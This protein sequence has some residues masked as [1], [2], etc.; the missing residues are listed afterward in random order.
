MIRTFRLGQVSSCLITCVYLLTGCLSPH[1][2]E[3]PAVPR[4]LI[5]EFNKNWLDSGQNRLLFHDSITKKQYLQDGWVFD[6]HPSETRFPWPRFTPEGGA[7]NL[8]WNQ[9][10]ERRVRIKLLNIHV[11]MIDD[12]VFMSIN[13]HP[14][15]R[16]EDP[17]PIGEYEFYLPSAYQNEGQNLLRI[18]LNPE[19]FPSPEDY[20]SIG[21]HSLH[22]TLGAVVK[23]AVRIGNQVRRSL[24]LAPPV[25][26]RIPY[27]AGADH[28]LQ[29]S[30]GLFRLD[31][32]RDLTRY[33]I[34][35]DVHE[36]GRSNAVLTR[37]IALGRDSNESTDWRFEK[38][39]LPAI[40]EHGV[41]AL[42]FEPSGPSV[43]TD[44]LA[45]SEAFLTPVQKNWEL[46][47]S[48][49][50][51]DIMLVTLASVSANQIGAYGNPC[52]RTP[53]LDTL[54]RKGCLLQD[55]TSTSNGEL[56]AIQSIAT[57]KYPR[58]HGIYRSLG[59]SMPQP[60]SIP[61][62][63]LKAGYQSHGFSYS[64][65]NASIPFARMDGFRR[66][67]L[68][69]PEQH[70]VMEVTSQFTDAVSSPFLVANPGFYWLHLA[71]KSTAVQNSPVTFHADQYGDR[72]VR[73][74]TLNLPASEIQRLQ[75]LFPVDTSHPDVRTLLAH[76]D[77][78]L[79]EWDSFLES[80]STVFAEKRGKR[81]LLMMITTDHGIIRSL[82]SNPLSADSL[83]QDVVK[84][85]FILAPATRTSSPTSPRI[86]SEPVSA[87]RI[88]D[89]VTELVQRGNMLH[90]QS[91]LSAL[92]TSNRSTLAPIFVEHE[93][94]PIVAY[95][96][97]RL[98]L[99][100]CLSDPYFQVATTSLFD[101]DTDP[102]ESFNLAGRDPASTRQMLEPVLAF[103]RGSS[104]YPEPRPGL[105]DE[106]LEILTALNY[107]GN[108][109]KR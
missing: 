57:G 102:S 34:S 35:I 76:N 64:I 15:M 29:F 18:S 14:I 54:S 30:F 99:I 59:N 60:V 104:Y 56:P 7:I 58:D 79:H 101:L 68:S 11:S 78:R 16:M 39:K 46:K 21:F 10:M 23:N 88:I 43:S 105:E 69:D 31:S 97:N 6:E 28:Y 95:R 100:H 12:P 37:K 17:L 44:Y 80:I 27:P 45:L 71:N 86:L 89:I 61:D 84:V 108:E 66:V 4:P 106:I 41:V 65:L 83:A 24:L 13:G 87:A 55:M 98:K 103:C 91:T 109:P 93:M 82:Q 52:A 38:I 107:T 50:E 70:P 40:R 92:M 33:T 8:N 77:H 5:E 73:P 94:R 63:L 49:T 20:R 53:F 96:K 81:S 26:L 42:S 47:R 72:L 85:P 9:R 25:T 3:P 74:E 48:G 36:T 1:P 90:A 22:V 67:Y 2:S 19:F 62:V 75:S 51:P 32:N